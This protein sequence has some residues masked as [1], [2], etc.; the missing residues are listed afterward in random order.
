MKKIR[1]E[2]KKREADEFWKRYKNLAGEDIDILNK[3][4]IGQST[5]STWKKMRR[6]PGADDAVRIAKAINKTVEWL[7]TGLEEAGLKDNEQVLLNAYNQLNDIGKE[8]AISAVRG[9]ISSFP[10]LPEV[11]ESIGMAT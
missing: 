8:A 6:F 10:Q 7:V 4:G 3:T 11:G 2:Q 5:L 1:P 9:L